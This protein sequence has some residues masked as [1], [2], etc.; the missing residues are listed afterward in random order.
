MSQ[1]SRKTKQINR[2]TQARRDQAQ[3]SSK[4][5]C[6]QITTNR[7]PTLPRHTNIKPQWT[8]T[9]LKLIEQFKKS[10]EAKWV[11][12]LN[13]MDTNIHMKKELRAA[14]LEFKLA[15]KPKPAW[16]RAL[17]SMQLTISP[18]LLPTRSL[19]AKLSHRQPLK[20]AMRLNLTRDEQ[21]RLAMAVW[22]ITTDIQAPLPILKT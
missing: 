14:Q 5:T 6:L 13:Q 17:C 21:P 12:I 7:M 10:E 18:R 22:I 2:L 19:E 20:Q 11:L 1:V 16:S 9:L 15:N 8:N 3:D 4:L